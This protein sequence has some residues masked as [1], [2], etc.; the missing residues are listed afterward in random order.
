M[1]AGNKPGCHVVD[2]HQQRVKD[3]GKQLLL[4]VVGI[5]NTKNKYQDIK[6]VYLSLVIFTR[7]LH[8][9]SLQFSHIL[10]HLY[11]SK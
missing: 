1:A 10:N 7:H 5:G 2:N 4:M 8:C 11:I 6:N 3:R 9:N